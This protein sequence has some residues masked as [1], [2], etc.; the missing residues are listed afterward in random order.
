MYETGLGG[1]VQGFGER[2]RL[3]FRVEEVDI[4]FLNLFGAS[5]IMIVVVWGLHWVP[6]S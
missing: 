4:G 6:A 5:T 3:Y 1:R 2:L